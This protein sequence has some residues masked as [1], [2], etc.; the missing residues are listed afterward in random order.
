[1]D[2]RAERAEENRGARELG[3]VDPGAGL[4]RDEKDLVLRACEGEGKAFDQLVLA[5]QRLIYSVCYRFVRNHD[6][7]NDLAQDTFLKA[8]QALH[9]FEPARPFRPWLVAIAANVS[10]SYLRRRSRWRKLSM[11]HQEDVASRSHGSGPNGAEALETEET[12]RAVQKGIDA[13]PPEYRAVLL[14][15]VQEHLSYDEIADAL[16]LPRGTVMSRLSRARE[17]LRKCLD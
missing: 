16:E 5:Y 11:K 2:A 8:Y 1:M 12:L 13:L 3:R 6:E 4:A 10:V 14:L 15:R 7:A 17:R 9:R